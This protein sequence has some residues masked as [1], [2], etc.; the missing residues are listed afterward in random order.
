MTHMTLLMRIWM[1]LVFDIRCLLSDD[2]DDLCVQRQYRFA[3]S[4]QQRLVQR[5]LQELCVFTGVNHTRVFPAFRAARYHQDGRDGVHEPVSQAVC[6]AVHHREIWGQSC[7]AIVERHRH[8]SLAPRSLGS[9]QTLMQSEDRLRGVNVKDA[10]VKAGIPE[11]QRNKKN[12]QGQKPKYNGDSL[13]QST[14]LTSKNYTE[15]Y[16]CHFLIN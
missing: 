2:V 15:A 4:G 3:V 16:M 14:I 5:H 13:I 1:T 6:T 10:G 11:L 9:L 7:N 8:V 12:L